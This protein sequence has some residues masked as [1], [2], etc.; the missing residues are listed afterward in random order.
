MWNKVSGQI[1]KRNN[2]TE[3]RMWVECNGKNREERVKM[4]Q[5][6]GKNGRGKAS[7]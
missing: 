2:K 4:V 5:A 3:L 7:E 1:E 6:C